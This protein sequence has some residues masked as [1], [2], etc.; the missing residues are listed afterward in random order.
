MMPI[1]ISYCR[2]TGLNF[3][4]IGIGEAG[5]R[6]IESYSYPS[7]EQKDDFWID[8]I[9]LCSKE[10]FQYMYDSPVLEHQKICQDIN[11]AN[12]VFI[13]VDTNNE[14]DCIDAYE[15]ASLINSQ[16]GSYDFTICVYCG[17]RN[18]TASHRLKSV[19]DKL[20]YVEDATLLNH[21]SY[22]ICMNFLRVG[23]MGVDYVDVINI[24]NKLSSGVFCQFISNDTI[25]ISEELLALS[26]NIK[27][28]GLDKSETLHALVHITIT[29]TTSLETVDKIILEI[30]K[31]IQGEMAW[32]AHINDNM[33]NNHLSIS[34]IYGEQKHQD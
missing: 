22:L 31:T 17:T 25:T 15:M 10:S 24:L 27:N 26:S 29:P 1:N 4:V 23:W 13:L 2:D 21:P 28:A 6:A 33:S 7:H 32:S 19:Y 14:A 16:K 5:K 20:I 9:V 30:G 8:N 3:V 34:M 18:C 12:L 11:K